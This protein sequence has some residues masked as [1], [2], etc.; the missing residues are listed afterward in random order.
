[1]STTLTDFTIGQ[2]KHLHAGK[3]RELYQAGLGEL[4]LVATDRLSAFDRVLQTAIPGKGAVLSSLSAWWFQQTADIVPNHLVRVVDPSACLVRA[5][6]PI[7]IEVVVRGF[8]CGSMARRY[9]A[10]EREFEGHT[11]PDGLR[12][13]DRLPE[14]IVTP[15]TKEKSDRPI[16]PAQIVSEGWTSARLWARME[17]VA[18]EL[19]R[20]GT[21]IL[22]EKGIILVDTKYEFGLL[23]GDLVLMDELHT[24]DSSRFWPV[25]SW[26]QE[27]LAA[28]Q[29]DKEFVRRWLMEN[30]EAGQYPTRLP[31]TVVGETVQRYRDIYERITGEAA[32]ALPRDAARRL[33]VNLVRNEVIKDG[34]VVI[35]MGSPIDEPHCLK[36]KEIVERYEVA[37]H[38]RVCSAH[39]NAEYLTALAGFYNRSIE[40]GAAVAVAG[41]S[42]GLGGAVAA[43]F[44]L[45]VTS[46][47]PFTDRMDL[48]INI[49]SSLMLPSRTP[50]GTV[51][52]PESAAML[53]L[54]GLNL[55]RLRRRFSGE[56]AAMKRDLAETDARLREK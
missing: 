4:L 54:R 51:V 7:R 34:Y 24:P 52:R 27:P 55:A 35:V 15:T 3:V 42:N 32:P 25:E 46:S 21:E 37:C 50:A 26:T 8:L 38:M 29:L 28:V 40:P 43:N 41:L 30:R 56:I 12:E 47:P 11:L 14:P 31:D 48:L 49:N 36:I 16:S 6:T 44:N 10:G 2:L 1:M 33:Y 39:K 45:P 22:I 9:A 17:T 18:L 53:A 19:F 5:C 13:N 20:R 23:D